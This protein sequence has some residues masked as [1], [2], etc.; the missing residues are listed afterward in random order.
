MP[1]KVALLDNNKKQL[2]KKPTVAGTTGLKRGI[3]MQQF[4]N[5]L[6]DC[7]VPRND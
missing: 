3:G 4:G 7:F 5:F 1:L 2:L 6:K